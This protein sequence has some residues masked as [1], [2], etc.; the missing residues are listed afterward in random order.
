[1]VK[2]YS[3]PPHGT[4]KG[5]PK[6]FMYIEEGDYWICKNHQKITFRG[7]RNGRNGVRKKIY[8]SK[9]SQ[10]KDCPFKVECIGKSKERKIELTA[11]KNEY[12]RTIERLENSTWHKGKRMS[13]VEPVFG[14]LKTFMGMKKVYTR[15]LD[16][17]NKCMLLAA[18]AYNLKKLLKFSSNDGS[19]P[20]G[21]QKIAKKSTKK[22][23]NLSFL[24]LLLFSFIYL[25]GGGTLIS[26]Y[27]PCYMK[28]HRNRAF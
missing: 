16:L 5:G 6:D 28:Q 23:Q 12:D 15:G 3:I 19:S 25:L 14:T 27:T 18:T 4:Y 22:D 21:K 24:D 20:S 1:M 10:C 8:F 2:S 17:T 13:T 11:Y 9:S 26:V 7:F